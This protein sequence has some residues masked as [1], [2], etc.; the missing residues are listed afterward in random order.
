[1]HTNVELKKNGYRRKI[2][3]IIRQHEKVS[4]FDVKKMSKY[5][6]TTTLETIEGLLHEGLIIET[7]VGESTG[8]R[9]PTWLSV[10]P[11]GGYF[12]GVEFNAEYIYSIILDF[13]GAIVY[14]GQEALPK[15]PVMVTLVVD[16]IKQA[17]RDMRFSLNENARIFGIGLGIPG[18]I[19]MEKGISLKYNY[20]LEWADVSLKQEI[21]TEFGLPVFIEN[22]VHA[23]AL[24]HKWLDYHG[25]C[26][27]IVF[28]AVRT[29]IRVSAVTNNHL[30]RGKHFAAGEIDHL[31]LPGSAVACPC[32]GY[33][34]LVSE[35]SN[36]ALVGKIEAGLQEGAFGAVRELM[37]LAGRDKP[38]IEDFVAALRLRDGDAIALAMDTARLLGAALAYVVLLYNPAR[39]I[40]SADWLRD[41]PICIGE[42]KKVVDER[43]PAYS[44]NNLRIE[45]SAY[46]LHVGAIGA[47]SIVLQSDHYL[48]N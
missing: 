27:D 30:L 43:C 15:H 17:I 18:F 40:L 4:R 38:M 33:G 3:R 28:M 25:E 35:V 44:T 2:M 6:M 39:I 46:G 5:S 7:G 11:E 41:A 19:D 29:G 14:R 13:S 48:L 9:K 12:F 45:T 26:E 34:C 32:G 20:I 21:E 37:L 47:A 16:R 8:G 22:N 10:N 31:R 24:A 1:M 36:G 42:I 23:M